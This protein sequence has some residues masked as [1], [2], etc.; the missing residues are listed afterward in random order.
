VT[1]AAPSDEAEHL[2]HE[3]F[4]SELVFSGDNGIDESEKTMATE[5][6]DSNVQNQTTLS[7]KRKADD[8]EGGPSASASLTDSSSTLQ[9]PPQQSSDRKKQKTDVQEEFD[10]ELE[11]EDLTRAS[12]EEVVDR[13]ATLA[14]PTKSLSLKLLRTTTE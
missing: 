6:G 10:L 9:S 7:S 5:D 1:V 11:P 12:S 14:P 8:G 3:A 13:S 4:G 2:A